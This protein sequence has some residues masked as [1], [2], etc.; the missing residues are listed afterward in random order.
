M[1]PDQTDCAW[2]GRSF[3]RGATNRGQRCC[4]A[5]CR[6]A[7]VGARR[8]QLERVLARWVDARGYVRGHAWR[9]GRRVKVLEHRFLMEQRLGRPLRAG[10]VVHHIN[11]NP[12]DNRIENLTLYPSSR[13]H[14]RAAHS[15]RSKPR[16]VA[17]VMES[18]HASSRRTRGSAF[19]SFSAR[20]PNDTIPRWPPSR[21]SRTR[22]CW[23]VCSMAASASTS[24]AAPSGPVNLSSA[25]SRPLDLP[26]GRRRA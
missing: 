17:D 23:S 9:D 8:R 12:S 3:N 5:A 14:L 11:A 13:E 22:S 6:S 4:S 15:R 1:S 19:S 7:W 18:S 2:C 25:I 21:G 16:D 10:E 24:C 20:S 26:T